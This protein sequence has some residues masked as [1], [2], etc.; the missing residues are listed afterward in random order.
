V[1]VVAGTCVTALL[2]GCSASP[3]ANPTAANDRSSAQCTSS[4]TPSGGFGVVVGATSSIG[5]DQ[6]VTDSAAWGRL[7]AAQ[8]EQLTQAL[9][10][11]D[12]HSDA[13][14][15]QTTADLHVSVGPQSGPPGRVP[16]RLV[17]DSTGAPAASGNL[18]ADGAVEPG[19]CLPGPQGTTHCDTLFGFG[20][21]TTPLTVSGHLDYSGTPVCV[22]YTGG[23]LCNGWFG[24]WGADGT[25]ENG[26]TGSG[27]GT[28]ALALTALGDVR[29]KLTSSP[30]ALYISHA[31]AGQ[32]SDV[33]VGSYITLLDI[34]LQTVPNSAQ[35]EPTK[36]ADSLVSPSMATPTP[37]AQF[38]GSCVDET[39]FGVRDGTDALAE[40]YASFVSA[41][42]LLT[43]DQSTQSVAAVA[44][45]A[46]AAHRWLIATPRDDLPTASD[47]PTG[48]SL[49]SSACPV[50]NSAL[51][52]GVTD[53]PYSC[54]Q[55]SAPVWHGVVQGQSLVSSQLSTT[56][57]AESDAGTGVIHVI[58][59]FDTV[60]VHECWP[61]ADCR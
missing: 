47:R 33:T 38:P 19:G 37:F 6:Y 28:S 4:S 52:P 26:S 21:G 2:A 42:S 7:P 45:A 48:A 59:A 16:A 10:A 3:T 13:G 43:Q 34:T 27:I 18:T 15:V 35:C 49:M 20:Q 54:T 8:Q 41:Q 40:P 56:A 39:A 5:G 53:A 60:D 25:A 36:L 24:A 57:Y 61:L 50:L 29:A 23:R 1:V 11:A 44:S 46:S 58:L 55:S 22:P 30:S 9:S 17:D 12:A 31:P 32:S 14:C 51:S